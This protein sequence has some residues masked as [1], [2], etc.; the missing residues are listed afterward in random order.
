MTFMKRFWP[1]MMIGLIAV[2]AA[3]F[4]VDTKDWSRFVTK[5]GSLSVMLPKNWNVADP[6]DPQLKQTMEKLKRDNPNMAAMFANNQSNQSIQLMAY[7]FADTNL[8]DGMENMNVIVQPN[9][10][11]TEKMYDDVGKEILSQMSFK[12]KSER[13]IVN[14]PVGKVLT[15]WG[16][17]EVKL[18][19]TSLEMDVLGAFFVKGDKMFVVTVALG[20]DGLKKQRPMV[21][22]IMK[23]IKVS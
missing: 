5:E 9:P 13:K 22:Q 2:A 12:G 16:T 11:V 15:Y 14:L 17:M 4:Q 3:A 8:A 20:K 10:G 18:E 6:N 7:N 19:G 21:D 1:V 23:T